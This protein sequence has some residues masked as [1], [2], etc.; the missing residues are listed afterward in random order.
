MPGGFIT[1]LHMKHNYQNCALFNIHRKKR[2]R[3][4]RK[5]NEVTKEQ[6]IANEELFSFFFTGV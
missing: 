4:K 1:L 3:R 2:R 6:M 5:R